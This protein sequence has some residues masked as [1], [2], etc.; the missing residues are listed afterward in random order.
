MEIKSYVQIWF[1]GLTQGALAA[2]PWWL[3]LKLSPFKHPLEPLPN[4]GESPN[5]ER[6]LRAE[7]RRRLLNPDGSLL[8]RS[9]A[10]PSEQRFTFAIWLIK[11]K[12]HRLLPTALFDEELLANLGWILHQRGKMKRRKG[13]ESKKVNKARPFGSKFTSCLICDLLGLEA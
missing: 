9:P 4:Q 6:G 12:W 7:L 10:A 5:E 13:D 2:Q 8:P 11:G 1:F 3:L